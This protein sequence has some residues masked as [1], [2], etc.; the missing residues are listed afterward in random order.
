[1]DQQ[2]V[3]DFESNPIYEHQ[4]QHQQQQL[5]AA[6]ITRRSHR[7]E[8]ALLVKILLKILNEAN[9][10]NLYHQVRLSVATCTKRNRMG[11]PSFS[12]IEDV[13]EAHL[14]LMVGDTYWEKATDL[15]QHYL[16]RK[17]MAAAANRLSRYRFHHRGA[18]TGVDPRSIVSL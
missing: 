14:W 15:Q 18:S 1:M 12:P 16:K 2:V 11:D 6:D 7:M 4:R 13:L 9:A 3:D 10:I 8:L 17:A 5:T